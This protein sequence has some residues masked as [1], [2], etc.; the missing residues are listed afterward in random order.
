[1]IVSSDLTFFSISLACAH[2]S[3]SNSASSNY[4]IERP[5]LRYCF[6]TYYIVCHCFNY[7][8][9][10]SFVL[11]RETAFL[12]YFSDA[13]VISTKRLTIILLKIAKLESS[14]IFILLWQKTLVKLVNDLCVGVLAGFFPSKV[15]KCVFYICNYLAAVNYQSIFLRFWI[16][17]TKVT[18]L[19]FDILQPFLPI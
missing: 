10:N 11:V 5:I 19:P 18:K 1:M 17:D 2:V 4:L 12:C 6:N 8:V 15:E 7:V 14:K 13:C 9:L 16:I 3:S